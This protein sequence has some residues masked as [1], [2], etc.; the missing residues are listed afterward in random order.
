MHV[1]RLERTGELIGQALPVGRAFGIDRQSQL[2]T[3]IGTGQ[4]FGGLGMA[5]LAGAGIPGHGMIL[6]AWVL[7]TAMLMDL[8]GAELGAGIT[9]VCGFDHITCATG[10]VLRGNPT[11]EQHVAILR[12]GSGMT[13]IGASLEKMHGQLLGPRRTRQPASMYQLLRQ[14]VLEPSKQ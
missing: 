9:T 5:R 6:A 3:T 4:T 10:L 2:A 12:K 8:P 14:T 13:G 1:Q 7:G 11:V